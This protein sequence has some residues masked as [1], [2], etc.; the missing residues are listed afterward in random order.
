[1]LIDS[2][3]INWIVGAGLG[4][5]GWYLKTLNTRLTELEIKGNTQSTEVATLKA[6]YLDIV[7]RLMRIEAK[8]DKSNGHN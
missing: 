8:L 2:S 1:M 7:N 4:V 5:V 3:V 6:H